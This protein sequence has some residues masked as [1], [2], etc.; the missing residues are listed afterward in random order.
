MVAEIKLVYCMAHK[1]TP[2]NKTADNLAKIAPKKAKHL[3][4]RPEISLAK[5]RKVNK[6]LTLQK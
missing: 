5:I 1:D 3:P 2:D 6:H 4:Q